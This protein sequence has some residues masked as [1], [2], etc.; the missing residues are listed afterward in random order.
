MSTSL[1]GQDYQNQQQLAENALNRN[2]QAQQTD[3]ARN[4]S[5]YQQDV[6]NRMGAA[7]QN[8]GLI[9]NASQGITGAN[10]LQSQFLGQYGNL[11]GGQQ[12]YQ[13]ALLDQ[14]ANNWYNQTYGY[15]Q[16]R[17]ANMGQALNSV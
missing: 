3:L 4:A 15:D 12:Q 9:L 2:V 13:Q 11:A 14:A 8:A 6:A 1:Y 7:Q 5:L 17:L 16:Q 10:A